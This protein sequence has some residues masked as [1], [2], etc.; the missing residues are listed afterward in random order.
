VTPPLVILVAG[1]IVVDGQVRGDPA[2]GLKPLPPE[3][4]PPV[5]PGFDRGLGN[6][7]WVV[8]DGTAS[9]TTDADGRFSIAGLTPG[10]HTVSVTKTVDGNLMQL[11][12]IIIVG[13]DGSAEVVAEVTWGMVRTTSTYTQGGA[14]MRAVFAGSGAHVITRAD[15]VVE[16]SDGYRTLRDADGDGRFDPDGCAGGGQL[17]RCDDATDCGA[18]RVCACIP[19]CPFCEDCPT[20]ACVPARS[21]DPATCAPDGS[22]KAVPPYACAAGDACAQTGGTCTCI[23]SCPACDDCQGSACVP[24]CE[25]TEI[26]RIDVYGPE[27]LIVGRDS[28]ASATVFFS[29][30][31]AMDV[32]GLATWASSDAAVATIDGWGRIKTV[33]VGTTNI[34]AALGDVTSAA[35]ALTVVE[36]PT[37]RRIYLQNASCYYPNPYADGTV[38]PLPPTMSDDVFAP[39][40]CERVLRVGATLQFIAIGEFDTNDY[41]D[42]TDE[43]EWRAEP[44]TVGEIALGVFTARAV[45]T[46]SVSATLDGLDSDVIEV[47]VVDHATVVDLSIYPRD[48]IFYMGPVPIREGEQIPC[49]TCG[50]FLLTM[51]RGDTLGFAA[52][53]HYDTG[54]WEDVSA[55]VTWR[56]SDASVAAF[57]ASG[58]LTA[59]GAG[60]ATLDATLGDVTSAPASIRVVARRRCSRSTPI[61]RAKTG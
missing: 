54:E 33:G 41:E 46:A 27:R 22:C 7:D 10:Q 14:A 60:A 61:R 58:V 28:N 34:T 31:T 36:R 37:L 4:M 13:G 56:S 30:G 47:R 26:V 42:L 16:I 40:S 38:R 49:D 6:A 17:Y 1:Q 8:D 20:R 23:A 15:A 11:T 52:T 43:V 44:A 9:G 18:D 50:Y 2:D 59:V 21:G 57:D 45:G 55:S 51:L 5:Y 25:A 48:R 32:T 12:L 29:D 53:A 19:S 24:S 39:P 3:S 35:L